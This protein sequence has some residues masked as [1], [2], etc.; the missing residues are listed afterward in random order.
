MYIVLLILLDSQCTCNAFFQV[1]LTHSTSQQLLE[2]C[3][4]L[5]Y[6]LQQ[7]SADPQ[8]PANQYNGHVGKDLQKKKSF[9][10][11]VKGKLWN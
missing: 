7:R 5:F 6:R 2:G 1:D 3:E 10:D 8:L 4:H 11:Q 9:R